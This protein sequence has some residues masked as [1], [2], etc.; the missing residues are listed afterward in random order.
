[1]TEKE[2]RK[3]ID[4]LNNGKSKESIFIRPLSDTVVI[5]KVWSEQPKPTD[6]IIG[7]FSSYRFFFI[8]DNFGKYVGAILDMYSDLHW[9]ISPK[10]RKKG[11]LTKALIETVLPYIFYDEREKQRI[12]I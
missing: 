5:S 6:S 4:R 12:T 8:K 10:H 3:Y 9:Y 11:H 7:N 1:M 2:I